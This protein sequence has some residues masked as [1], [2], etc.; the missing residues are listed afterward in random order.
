MSKFLS[1]GKILHCK[2]VAEIMYNIALNC[3]GY[4]EDIA[5]E[6]YALGF[7]HDIGYNRID[8][9]EHHGFKGAA[10]LPGYR[11]SGE[12]LYHGDASQRFYSEYIKILNFADMHVLSDGSIVSMSTRLDDIRER[13]GTKS[14]QTEGAEVIAETTYPSSWYA[15]MEN[16]YGV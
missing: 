15:L 9:S 4:E 12:V 2:A 6:M 13:Y 16:Q 3:C 5:E 1:E 11:Y 8:E 14:R 7:I 10:M